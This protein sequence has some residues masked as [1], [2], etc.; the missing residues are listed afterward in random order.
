MI[1]KFDKENNWFLRRNRMCQLLKD[2]K[3]SIFGIQEG[4]VQKMAFISHFQNIII[5][6]LGDDGKLKGEFCAI[7]YD[8]TRFENKKNSTFLI[9]ETPDVVSVGWDAALERICTY[10]L[11]IEKIIW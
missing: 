3:P 2:Y 11:F 7:F 5:S 4:L 8:T 1:I 9:S 6:V 10:G